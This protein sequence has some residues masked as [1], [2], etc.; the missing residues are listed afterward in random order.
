M[1]SIILLNL[2]L[3]AL[4]IALTAFFVGAEF[5]ILKVR[6]SR[7]DQLIA[8]G[9]KKAV[10]AKKVAHDL[11]YY[12]S[13][14]QLGITITALILGA[15]GEPTVEKILHPVFES[16]ELSDTMATVLSYAIALSLV[17]F[18]HVVLGELAP[19]TLAIQF[20][21]R[22]TLLLAPPLYWFG[23]IMSPFIWALN[24]AARIFLRMFGVEPAG[25]DEVHSEEELKLIMHQSFESGEI[26]QTELNY[27]EN[28]FA[29]DER[30]IKDIMIPRKQIVT[31]EKDI[32]FE[33]MIAVFDEND[34]TRYPVTEAHDKDQVIG[35]LN[36]KEML[37]H[38]A[39]GNDRE[40][41]RFIH[42][43]PRFHEATPIQAVLL[44]M[45]Q[46]RTHM[47]IVTDEYGGTAGV[48]TMEDI[49]EEIVGEI[50]DE[51]DTDELPDIQ[52]KSDSEY[53]V[54]GRVMLTDLEERFNLDFPDSE[55]LDTIGGWIQTQSDKVPE[56]GDTIELQSHLWTV[57]EME[58][59]QVKRV[60]LQ[61]NTVSNS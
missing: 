50:R 36:T 5:A 14:C 25:H 11:D 1:D 53:V 31:L 46:S 30:M 2:F 29:F 20:A 49:L 60:E 19:K 52:L 41:E 43:M 39:A 48:V 38:I 51:Y 23:K 55:D 17:T 59:Y 15:L 18:L 40:M 42:D 9:N 28:I 44:K 47:A 45:Q 4:M 22:M 6:M 33:D 21:E 26:N 8:E 56:E 13:A 7:I 58:S 24:G 57:I 10:L 61:L 54:N 32:S 35:F 27:L 12:L 37:T 34:Y 16:M 3:V